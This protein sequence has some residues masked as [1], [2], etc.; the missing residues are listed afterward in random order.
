MDDAPNPTAANLFIDGRFAPAHSRSRL[1][2]VDPATTAVLASVADAD[3]AD[4]DRAVAAARAAFDG[5]WRAVAARERGRILNRIGA[6]IRARAGELAELETRNTG[7]PIVE[8]ESDMEEA[9]AC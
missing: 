5:P 2:I 3:G 4:V 7:K 6:A 1:Q 9:A 8:S